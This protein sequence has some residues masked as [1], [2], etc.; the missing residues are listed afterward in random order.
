MYPVEDDLESDV[1][2]ESAVPELYKR[3]KI[4]EQRLAQIEQMTK[5]Y[6]Q[7][8]SEQ[9]SALSRPTDLTYQN[10]GQYIDDPTQADTGAFALGRSTPTGQPVSTIPAV[11]Q[12]PVEQAPAQYVQPTVSG[13]AAQPAPVQ[14]NGGKSLSAGVQQW[15]PL[16]TEI[17]NKYG[18]DPEKALAI[19][20]IESGG[21]AGITNQKGAPY[22]GLF[23]ISTKIKGWN[24]PRINTE[25]A[26]KQMATRSN[27]FKKAYGREPSAGELYLMQQQGE[28]G[29]MALLNPKNA[30]RPVE[31]V[32]AEVP[33]WKRRYGG[34]PNKVL[35]HVV[36]TNGGSAGMTAAQFASQWIGKANNVYGNSGT[37]EAS[38]GSSK[39]TQVAQ[40]KVLTSE[41]KPQSKKE[42]KRQV[43]NDEASNIKAQMDEIQKHMSLPNVNQAT[44]NALQ[45]RFK[46]LKLTYDAINREKGRI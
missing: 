28:G 19:M 8:L 43:L 15:R 18:I 12:Q 23:Q 45:G 33:E 41:A 22:G 9:L 46:E 37:V 1:I 39:P 7:P 30:N 26:L 11:V 21:K 4:E 5:L 20:Q 25:T 36:K 17:A 31:Q 2:A 10:D 13:N 29:A 3:R 38:N 44:F 34:D 32:L 27:M 35:N 14:S 24:D 42:Y 6:T 16:V 40:R